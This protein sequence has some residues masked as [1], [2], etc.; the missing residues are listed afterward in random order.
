MQV[1][2]TDIRQVIDT[3]PKDLPQTYERILSRIVRDGKEPVV[4]KVYRWI[5]VAKRPLLLEELR[6]A[7]AI[8]PCQCEFMS[9]R[10]VNDISGIV[11]WCGNLIIL[12]D[13][14]QSIQSAHH[15][16]QDFLVSENYKAV[17]GSFHFQLSEM[18]HEAGEICV[19]YLNFNNFQRQLIKPLKSYPSF[20]PEDIAATSLSAAGGSTTS[21]LLSKVVRLSKT[22]QE[23]CIN[24]SCQLR[25]QV[26]SSE[27]S[28]YKELKKQYAFLAYASENWLLHTSNFTAK[29]KTWRM[30]KQLVTADTQFITQPW[31][32][33]EWAHGHDKIM[34]YILD[35]NHMALLLAVLETKWRW[36]CLSIL[37]SAIKNRLLNLVDVILK[38]HV[39]TTKDD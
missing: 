23:K 8:R 12:D 14:D 33:D 13:E 1:C 29:T 25:S 37:M 7:I 6:E 20:L 19:T 4:Q 22:K 16:V 27:I 5:A 17:T 18:D 26:K 35:K 21:R 9:D 36:K 15:T 3:L 38:S 10:L 39:L 2:D 28:N 34:R 24:V 31:T 11:S 32:A 30:W